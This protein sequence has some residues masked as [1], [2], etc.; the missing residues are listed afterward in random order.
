VSIIPLPQKQGIEKKPMSAAGKGREGGR[1][2]GIWEGIKRDRGYTAAKY[3]SR[4]GL[5]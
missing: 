5:M 2:G 1:R 4:N 3:P